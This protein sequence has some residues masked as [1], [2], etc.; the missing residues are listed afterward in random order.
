MT[1]E[2]N[3][4]ESRD[5]HTMV[6]WTSL[7]IQLEVL[8]W[9]IMQLAVSV[10]PGVYSRC[11]DSPAFSHALKAVALIFETCITNV[12]GSPQQTHMGI[13]SEFRRFIVAGW[14][15]N[16]LTACRCCTSGAFVYDEIQTEHKRWRMMEVQR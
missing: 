14:N 4:Q 10:Q 8:N 16:Y 12:H 6:V 9:P 11:V 2:G 3:Y 15:F 7:G 1:L 13:V 5:I